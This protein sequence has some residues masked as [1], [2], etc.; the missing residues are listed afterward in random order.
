MMNLDD[1]LITKRD[2]LVT[3]IAKTVPD[4]QNAAS[5]IVVARQRIQQLSI[6]SEI[7]VEAIRFISCLPIADKRSP[8]A[9]VGSGLRLQERAD[10]RIPENPQPEPL[11]A[12]QMRSRIEDRVITRPPHER[13][14]QT[15][16]CVHPLM[17]E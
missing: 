10:F 8:C 6:N 5:Q 9:V 4:R 7:G 3:L 2:C 12:G 14:D 13:K 16:S 11:L 15:L 17:S 1:H